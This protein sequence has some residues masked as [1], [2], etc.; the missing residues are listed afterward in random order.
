[1]PSLLF[2]HIL[3]RCHTVRSKIRR[4][5]KHAVVKKSQSPSQ[6]RIYPTAA[7][8]LSPLGRCTHRQITASFRCPIHCICQFRE[9]TLCQKF[10]TVHL[11]PAPY[12]KS[13]H[14]QNMI[15]IPAYDTPQLFHM[16]FDQRYRGRLPFHA[17]SLCVIG[18]PQDKL[19]FLTGKIFQDTTDVRKSSF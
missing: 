13:L 11:S 18:K 1:M 10:G 7:D 16:S 14:H 4:R 3:P 12:Q 15:S 19:L 2:S 6:C 8:N 9:I 17:P 5:A